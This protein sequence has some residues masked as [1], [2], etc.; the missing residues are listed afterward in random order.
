MVKR[1]H[2]LGFTKKSSTLPRVV[3]AEESKNG[4]RFEIE[5]SCYG[6]VPT[7]SQLVTRGQSSCY[8]HNRFTYKTAGVLLYY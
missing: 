5:P 2:F 6:A 7:R 4:L 8:L 3:W 1:D